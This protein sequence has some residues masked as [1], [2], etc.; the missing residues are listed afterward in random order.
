MN[1]QQ[2]KHASSNRDWAGLIVAVLLFAWIHIVTWIIHALTWTIEQFL[3]VAGIDWPWWIW[4][5]VA[6]AHVALT[7]VPLLPLAWFWRRARYRAVFQTWTLAALYVLCLAP[8]R[9]AAV[10]RAQLAALLQILGQAAYVLALTGLL[11]FRQRQGQAGFVRPKRL[12]LPAVALAVLTGW[13]WLAWGAF[14]SGVDTLLNLISAALLGLSSGL[15]FG[16]FLLDPLEATG[17]GPGWNIALGGATIDASLALMG[18]ALG[19]NGQQLLL[20][21]ILPAL[22]WALTA[23]TRL[24]RERPASGWL[25]LG[26]AV[27]LAAAAPML[28]VDPDELAL[29]LNLET[30]DVLTWSLYASIVTVA[31]GLA[32]GLIGW[33]FRRRLPA[34]KNRTAWGVATLVLS[35][36]VLLIYLI[37]GQPG[38]YGERLYVIMADQADLSA[39]AQIDDYANR[40]QVVYDELVEH[41]NSTQAGIRK[42][43]DLL[44][45]DYTPYYLVNALEVNAG[46]LIRLWLSTRPEVDRVLDSPRLRPLP[47]P[48]P[49]S[50]GSESAPTTVPWNVQLIGAD[51]V[52]REFGATGQG[53]VIGQSDSGAQLDHPE[54]A[55]A[56]RGKGGNHDYNWYDPWNHTTQPTDVGGHG[57]HTLGSILGQNTGIAPGAEWYGCT[58]LARNLAN[59]ALYLDC[60]Q[61]MLAPFPLDGDPLADGKPELGAHVI[62]N[63]WGCPDIEGCDPNALVDAVRALRAAGVFVVASA[64]NEGSQCGSVDSPL[65]LYDD[66]FS[67]GAVDAQGTLAFFSSRGPVDAD[68][69]NRVKPDILAPGV[70]VLS[71]YPGSTYYTASGTS[72]AGPH[73]VGV[74][75]LIWSANPDLIGDIDRTEQIIIETAQP[76]DYALHGVPTCGDVAR[77][78]DNAVGYGI[79]D[80]YA[81]VK[82]ALE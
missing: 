24:G 62:N 39:A 15:I 73:V 36:I 23:L 16:H 9:L 19:F 3:I 64:G 69:S 48:V 33:V 56:Y 34:W 21:L 67:V 18:S 31:T 42:T 4:P 2:D 74:V 7:A 41:A 1:D 82:M 22:G 80:A 28:W 14:G 60:M 27:A 51:R 29:V 37:A 63:S 70:D 54:F 59:P 76:Y 30:H 49:P 20:L 8:A 17:N 57:S 38:F 26:L 52:W 10:N 53:I 68:G 61:F 44:R 79:I 58:N 11:W 55:G 66:A 6:L 46:P 71:A 13:A 77:T 50:H 25:A 12:Y 81:A 45:I 5:A 43:L 65:A 40:R 32:L 72:M 78:P 35:A 47:A 75:A